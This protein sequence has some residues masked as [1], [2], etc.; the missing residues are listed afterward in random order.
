MLCS[1]HT[2]FFSPIIFAANNGHLSTVK[3]L[4]EMGANINDRSNNFRTPLIWSSIWGHYDVCKYLIEKGAN[5]SAADSDGMTALMLA[6]AKSQNDIVYLLIDQ[7]KAITVSNKF[8]GTALSIAEAKGDISIEEAL[9]PFF[10]KKR[11]ESVLDSPYA[12]LLSNLQRELYKFHNI[13]ISELNLILDLDSFSVAMWNT[14]LV[15]LLLHYAVQSVK[16]KK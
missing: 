15:I 12:I 13:S 11:N 5:V 16:P 4:I 1:H 6:V 10:L 3:V 14:L 2:I 8:G 9:R 7:N